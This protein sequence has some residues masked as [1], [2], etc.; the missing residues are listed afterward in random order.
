VGGAEV[1]LILGTIE[2]KTDSAVCVAAINVVDEYGLDLLNHDIL[3][4]RLG[5]ATSQSRGSF[6]FGRVQTPENKNF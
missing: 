2:S 5:R 6:C 4:L 1:D 3:Q